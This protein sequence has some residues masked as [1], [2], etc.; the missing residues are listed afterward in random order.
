MQNNILT[1]KEWFWTDV[2]YPTGRR[3]NSLNYS[4]YPI[5]SFENNPIILPYT[6]VP[7]LAI[8]NAL[9]QFLPPTSR[10]LPI[11][12]GNGNNN[13][14]VN[15]ISSVHEY[16]SLPREKDDINN[17]NKNNDAFIATPSKDYSLSLST[18]PLLS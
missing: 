18:S 14:D 6:L 13:S 8:G 1:G 12:P 11:S 2:D 16:E 10:P 7:F 17:N 15:G 4:A 9:F 3:G 5:C